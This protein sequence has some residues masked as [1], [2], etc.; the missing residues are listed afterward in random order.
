M[1]KI[2]TI[3]FHRNNILSLVHL[4]FFYDL[5]CL[6]RL[7]KS[8][9]PKSIL[10]IIT[11]TRHAEHP[12]CGGC[13]DLWLCAQLC[14]LPHISNTKPLQWRH[15]IRSTVRSFC[16]DTYIEIGTVWPPSGLCR[17]QPISV[18]NKLNFLIIWYFLLYIVFST[19]SSNCSLIELKNII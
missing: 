17:R 12:N 8:V 11:I 13:P 3:T 9:A 10:P 18:I 15:G 5:E 1:F 6:V 2:W 4:F 16:Q 19:C 7:L 14:T